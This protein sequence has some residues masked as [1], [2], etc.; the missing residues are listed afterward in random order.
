M[1]KGCIDK[2]INIEE[3][4]FEPTEKVVC[5][6][7]RVSLQMPLTERAKLYS[8]KFP[9]FPPLRADKRWI[10]GMWIMGNNY[11]TSGYYGAYPHGY[12]K[13][14]MSLFPDCKNILHLFGGS[15]PE[16][17]YTRFDI[18]PEYADVVGDAHELSKYFDA[19]T[20]DLILADPPYSVEDA[21]HYGTCM[22]NRNKVLRECVPILK[23]GG[24]IVWLDQVLPMF[25][26][27][28]LQMIGVIG[29]VKST[30][31]RFRVVTIFQRHLSS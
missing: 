19:E 17:D 25:R 24:F 7:N 20:F 4:N 16:G 2:K 1:Q 5:L 6:K 29:M 12:L 11:T 30:N 8:Q 22:I 18:K 31:H 21:E 14:I 9:S 10:D 15:L 3:N 23:Q 28:E 13:R 27:K 26:K